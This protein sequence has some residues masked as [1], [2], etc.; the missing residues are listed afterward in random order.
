MKM[1]ARFPSAIRPARNV[2]ELYQFHRRRGSGWSRYAG[3]KCLV[4]LT[5]V[6]GAIG[7]VAAYKLTTLV[8][9]FVDIDNWKRKILS[10]ITP[11]KHRSRRAGRRYIYS[12]LCHRRTD[13][14]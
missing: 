2:G 4:Q 10:L 3:R 1:F 13:L 12:S 7:T 6:A 11:S 9:P 8:S 14:R 5:S